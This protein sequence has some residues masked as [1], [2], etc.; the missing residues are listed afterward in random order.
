[1]PRQQRQ[2]GLAGILLATQLFN[3][4]LGNIPIVTLVTLCLN[5]AIFY[6]LLDGVGPW[7][8]TLLYPDRSCVSLKHVLHGEDWKRLVLAGLVHADEWHL[9]YNMVSFLW[10]GRMLERKLGSQHFAC[11]LVVFTPLINIVMLLL[12]YV[13]GE[14]VLHDHSYFYHCAVGFSGVIFALKVLATYEAAPGSVDYISGMPVPSRYACWAELLLIQLVTPNASFT[15][16]L[17]GILVGLAYVWGPLRSLTDVL[18]PSAPSY[19]YWSGS[20]AGARRA[21]GGGSSQRP[22]GSWWTNRQQQPSSMRPAYDEYTGG[23]SEDEQL[24]RATQASMTSAQRSPG[25]GWN[26]TPSSNSGMASG[27]CARVP[28]SSSATPSAPL[29]SDDELENLR[30]RRLQRLERFQ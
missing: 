3:I 19:T 7:P 11:L 28:T 5:A 24:W 1:M 23:L 22:S 30:L 14:H 10:K 16:H 2:P 25:F 8:A 29:D 18:V 21:G 4:G 9:Y 27:D 17:A 20:T 6:G 26:S 15:G 13:L 12:N